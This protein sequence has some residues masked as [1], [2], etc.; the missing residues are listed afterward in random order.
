[1]AHPYCPFFE[2]PSVCNNRGRPNLAAGWGWGCE[3]KTHPPGVQVPPLGVGT[4]ITFQQFRGSGGRAGRARKEKGGD[5]AEPSGHISK[6]LGPPM[7]WLFPRSPLHPI[8]GN[9]PHL[10]LWRVQLAGCLGPASARTC[11]REGSAVQNPE[12]PG[13]AGQDAEVRGRGRGA[14]DFRPLRVR[15]CLSWRPRRGSRAP[16]SLPED[17]SGGRPF[18]PRC[19]PHTPRPVPGEG[20]GS[21]S[22]PVSGKFLGAPR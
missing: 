6:A 2:V 15:K 12:S 14:Q 5:Y 10:L 13:P 1:M 11:A 8:N 20:L 21:L 3:G 17:S 9:S 22:A 16:V 18:S 4:Q 7:L 19:C